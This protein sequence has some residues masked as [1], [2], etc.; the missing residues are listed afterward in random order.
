MSAA[1]PSAVRPW[2]AA[3]IPPAYAAPS[4]SPVAG[5]PSGLTATTIDTGSVRL[6]WADGVSN[7]TLYEVQRAPY[8]ASACGTF[9][10]VGAISRD[11]TG[12]VA[13]GLVV[14]TEYCFRVRASN[15]YGGGSVTAWSNV[16]VGRTSDPPPPYTCA[17]V[18]Y[19]WVAPAVTTPL[20]MS[21]DS[22]AEVAL[23]T[24]FSFALY[25]SAVT[26]VGI[27]SNG[28]LRA[29]QV[30]GS[31]YTNG[32]IPDAAEPNGLI[33][34]A[35]DD[36]NP[37]AGGQVVHGVT[38]TAGSRR[39][40]VSW[41][42]VP[43]YSPT[44]SPVTFQAVLEEGTGAIRFA[45]ADMVTGSSLYDGGASATA[46]V[47][48]PDGS[49]G[50]LISAN[51]RTLTD[52]KAFRCSTASGVPPA[53][54]ATTYADGTRGTAYAAAT[55]A[56]GGNEPYAWSLDSGSLPGGL[57]LDPTSGT[58]RGT[59][60]TKQS[61]SFVL[62]VTGADG[63]TSTRAATIAIF[64]PLSISTTSLP[65]GSTGSAYSAA[66]AGAGGNGAY[67][68]VFEWSGG[69]T[70]DGISTT[71]GTTSATVRGTPTTA[72]SFPVRVKVA[73]AGGRTATRDLTLSI[74]WV[75]RSPGNATKLARGAT[76]A[77]LA[78]WPLAGASAYR[79]CH[80]T[81]TGCTAW[82]AAGTSTTASLTGLALGTTYYWQVQA[83]VG[84][85]WVGANGT[86]Y[87]R[88]QTVR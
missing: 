84:G 68:W 15:N 77:T 23:P 88:F 20:A 53:I 54:A 65:A 9:S 48:S 58:I 29:G 22:V 14:S 78:W 44:T 64:D 85:T 75:K 82:V 28:F 61:A 27:S 80:R 8:A 60:T 74:P 73:D 55:S 2:Q 87:W 6:A 4:A 86:T 25:G 35:W 41:I 21:D 38:G 12:Y 17:P 66:I 19:E 70:P 42:G 59:P 7:E 56:T 36:W 50:T 16:A 81:T 33:A 32:S 1:A 31:F 26:S 11:S 69:T 76:A 63:G 43:H 52:G 72:G 57:T 47:E 46:G 34:P 83:S 79:Y 45:Y 49:W 51:S 71:S 10:T 5:A 39:F 37:A 67:T 13:S 30:G 18:A 40:V 24:G 3:S 62:R